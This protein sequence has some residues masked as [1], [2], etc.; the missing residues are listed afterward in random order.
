MNGLLKVL[1]EIG[2]RVP[3]KRTIYLVF[4]VKVMH[5]SATE[6]S[7]LLSVRCNFPDF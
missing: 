2:T 4:K 6:P 3:D 7:G 1:N 5:A